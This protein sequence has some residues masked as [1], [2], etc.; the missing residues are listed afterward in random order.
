MS[1]LVNATIRC[2]KVVNESKHKF[3]F[4]A[5]DAVISSKGSDCCA[6]FSHYNEA[7]EQPR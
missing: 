1:Y 2:S 3:D 6:M 5:Y 7:R 4:Q